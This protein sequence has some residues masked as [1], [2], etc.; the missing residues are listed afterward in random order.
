MASCEKC[1]DDAGIRSRFIGKRKVECYHDLLEERKNNPCS[2]REQAGQFWDEENQCDR[3]ILKLLK[4]RLKVIEK[5][6]MNIYAEFKKVYPDLRRL[7]FEIDKYD[8]RSDLKLHGF[9]H[10]GNNCEIYDNI[11][12]HKHQILFQKFDHVL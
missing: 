1:W 4:W 9:Y 7:T 12:W 3:R 5:E 6:L 11:D 10:E 8:H 2:L